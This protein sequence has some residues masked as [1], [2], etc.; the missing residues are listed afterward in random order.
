MHSEAND[1][2]ARS[3]SKADA[4]WHAKHTEHHVGGIARHEKQLA[5]LAV[6]HEEQAQKLRAAPL[7]K[8]KS[9]AAKRNAVVQVLCEHHENFLMA[10]E[11]VATAKAIWHWAHDH[12][13]QDDIVEKHRSQW[14]RRRNIIPRIEARHL[15]D[16]DVRAS[17]MQLQRSPD[18]LAVQACGFRMLHMLTAS[19]D[20]AALRAL[21]YGAVKVACDGLRFALTCG[22]GEHEP[23][24]AAAATT[25]TTA[26]TAVDNGGD[27]V[28]GAGDA[29]ATA[30]GGGGSRPATMA[31]ESATGQNQQEAV[32][33]QELL[34]MQEEEEAGGGEGEVESA[35]LQ[36]ARPAVAVLANLGR[37]DEVARYQLSALGAF[38]SAVQAAQRFPGDR[39]LQRNLCDLL[40]GLC[41]DD[42]A[43]T[44]ASQGGTTVVL[45]LRNVSEEM[46]WP[47]EQVR[48]QAKAIVKRA[49]KLREA[50]AAGAKVAESSNKSDWSADG[51]PQQWAGAELFARLRA[52]HV[53]AADMRLLT[54]ALDAV[55]ALCAKHDDNKR[56]ACSHGLLPILLGLLA[57]YGNPTILNESRYEGSQVV[58]R[59]LR[60]VWT[61]CYDPH[62]DFG[63]DVM[64]KIASE[65]TSAEG[66]SMMCTAA[67]THLEDAPVQMALQQAAYAI[68]SALGGV[69]KAK[70]VSEIGNPVR[71]GKTD[72]SIVPSPQLVESTVAAMRAHPQITSLIWQ[73]SVNVT[74]M[75]QLHSMAPSWWMRADGPTVFTDAFVA[76]LYV[77]PVQE[78]LL[79]CFWSLCQGPTGSKRAARL[80]SSVIPKQLQRVL[81]V[82]RE[83]PSILHWA[84][85]A[86]SAL[87]RA[88]EED[89]D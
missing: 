39:A 62:P 69:K 38:D 2:W 85:Q 28:A 37:V 20:D 60:C 26:M 83:A 82:H 7:S 64:Y 5:D 54:A 48:A 88:S 45:V 21:E 61:L 65:L 58:S 14:A 23:T 71:D 11:D 72:M 18:D 63:D 36:A 80:R 56:D 4:K 67:R 27:D 87:S 13:Y 89:D 35:V 78:Q 19:S 73:G 43:R 42:I 68:L 46:G 3:A 9:E 79:Q 50:R 57:H 40:T 31:L 47:V 84:N 22:R 55:M 6:E 15:R 29:N 33:Q 12:Q 86:K 75:V 24:A 41:C 10:I 49:G 17:I 66:M 70:T 77:E 34:L 76:H 30:G 8:R 32:A 25:T 53:R 16:P 81:F 59:A 51:K 44:L 1:A 74:L 52:A